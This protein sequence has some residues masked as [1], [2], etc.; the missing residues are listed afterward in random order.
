MKIY[1]KFL[2]GSFLKSFIFI[3]LIMYSLSFI[4]NLISEIEFFKDLNVS[5]LKP[6]FFTFLNSPALIFELLPFIFLLTTQ[7]FFIS[8]LKD[9]QF[10]IFKYSGIKNFKIIKIIAIFAL[11]LGFLLIIF[12][13]N[14]SSNL[15]NLYL[16]LKSPYT[17][18]DKYLA[19]ITKNGL[20]IKDKIDNK[21]II[22]NSKEIKNNFLI[23]A[24]ITEFNYDYEIIRN[25]QSEKIDIKENKWKIYDAKIYDKNSK[26][27]KD[28]LEINSN[29]NYEKIQTLFSNLSSLSII[30]L[31]I[32]K[33]NY[34]QLG[35]STIEVD[36]H[37][38]KLILYPIYFM[39]LVIFAS[40]I[41]LN[42]KKIKNNTFKIS[43]GLFLS[44]VIYYI[45]NFFYILGSTERISTIISV[46][47]PMLI[48]SFFNLIFLKSINEK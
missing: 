45:N 40:T 28:I 27:I 23:N 38:L 8:I 43:L 2:I 11:I 21:I 37:I 39:L 41:M 30:E 15:K 1:T 5:F 20:W 29:F 17:T 12:F 26:N 7:L 6:I 34:K 10:E 24:F 42:F 16:S 18:D 13:Y 47:L 4:L 3:S 36:I 44:V 19:V 22:I 9:N 35:Y 32:L 48:L 31:T 46:L 14:I 33:D 25:I